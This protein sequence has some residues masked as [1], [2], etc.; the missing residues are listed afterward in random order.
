MANTYK[1]II[2]TA[3]RN[4]NSADPNVS[5]RG[6]NS[7]SNTEILLRVY[8]DSNGTLSFEGSAGQLFS[9]TNDL[10]GSIF[11]VNDVSGIP[12][13]EAFANGTVSLAQYSGNVAIGSGGIRYSTNSNFF[14]SSSL[15]SSP[16][17]TITT[18]FDNIVI[19][20]NASRSLTTGRG[21]ITFGE[22]AGCLNTKGQY[23]IFIG[24]LTGANTGGYNDHNIVMG[25]A[26]ASKC[27][28]IG[29]YNVI[30]GRCAGAEGRYGYCNIIIGSSTAYYYC[31]SENVVIG[32]GAGLNMKG[33]YNVIIG[34]YAGCGTFSSS[35]PQFSGACNVIIGR[36]AGRKMTTGTRNIFIGQAAGYCNSSGDFNIVL[37]CYGGYK[38]TTACYN[39][40]LGEKTGC[41]V[42]TGSNNLFFGRWAGTTGGTVGGL[43]NITTESNRIV[44][45]NAS[46]ACAQIQIAWTTVSDV[47]DKHIIGPVNRG[48]GFLQG[49]TPI[50][51]KFKDRTTGCITDP[52]ATKRYGFS[53]QEILALEGNDPVIVSQE[54]PDKLFMTSDYLIP[55]LVNAIKE[56]STELDEVK[57]RLSLLENK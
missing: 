47:R 40:M 51:F 17:S 1:D 36:F 11:S 16:A 49:L 18:G 7:A 46:H 30:L 13:I 41:N 43:A 50:E 57:S 52:P 42:T 2:I 22:R 32:P 4:S 10:T 19:G 5:F 27:S 14:V 37:G 53:A 44:M 54:N 15:G 25:S 55:V 29:G 26:S 23:N 24:R 35:A 20:N 38:A 48:R 21:N 9:I 45:G 3:N 39:V 34:S 31:G 33:G 28:D 12:S 8:P 6:A 56:L